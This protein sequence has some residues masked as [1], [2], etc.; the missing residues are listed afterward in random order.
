MYPS[1]TLI[2]KR[3]M[4]ITP[5]DIWFSMPHRNTFISF[6]VREIT[7]SL[8]LDSYMQFLSCFFEENGVECDELNTEYMGHLTGMVKFGTSEEK[9][10]ELLNRFI[11]EKLPIRKTKSKARK[12][13]HKKQA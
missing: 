5:Q 9:I 2:Q 1:L 13:R 10:A 11:D 3:E 4:K 8:M 6:A 7:E 12:L